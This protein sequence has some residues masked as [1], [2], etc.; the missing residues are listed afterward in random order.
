MGLPGTNR[1][2]A[3]LFV[4]VASPSPSGRGLTAAPIRRELKMCFV[5]AVINMPVGM[6][7]TILLNTGC[8]CECWGSKPATFRQRRTLKCLFRLLYLL[9]P[10]N[11][12]SGL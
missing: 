7:E 5:F 6:S 12:S 3:I 9:I 2:L 8:D 4:V 11:I 10:S 1:K